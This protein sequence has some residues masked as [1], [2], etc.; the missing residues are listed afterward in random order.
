RL[1]RALHSSRAIVE[2]AE[3]VPGVLLGPKRAYCRFSSTLR[4]RP[5]ARRTNA[6]AAHD[7]SGPAAPGAT[8]RSH[9]RIR[10]DAGQDD[11][12][13]AAGSLC[14]LSLD[15]PLVHLLR[16]AA[17][18]TITWWAGS[19]ASSSRTSRSGRRSHA[20]PA[21]QTLGVSPAAASQH[22]PERLDQGD[23]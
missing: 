17:L 13:T 14:R 5:D 23:P 2:G 20:A 19:I 18:S 11:G 8:S 6:S 16:Y 15:N 9:H 4:L 3:V 10:A 21:V 22:L 1:L 12:R 7:F